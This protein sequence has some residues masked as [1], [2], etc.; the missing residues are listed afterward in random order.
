M[1][2]VRKKVNPLLHKH[3]HTLT[4]ACADANTLA[5]EY[6]RMQILVGSITSSSLKHATS[7]NLPRLMCV[8]PTE[9]STHILRSV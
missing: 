3:T 9:H 8:L 1:N 6:T 5:H 7:A 4:T 2:T